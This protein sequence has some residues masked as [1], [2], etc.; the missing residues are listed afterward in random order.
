[1]TTHRL[2]ID[3]I[4]VGLLRIGSVDQ[5]YGVDHYVL[6]RPHGDTITQEQAER[7]MADTYH[8]DPTRPGGLFC[9]HTRA[10]PDGDRWI[11]IAAIRYDV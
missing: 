9:H 10:I 3:G 7:L 1:M 5:E 11:G 6:L 8:R 2:E 4:V